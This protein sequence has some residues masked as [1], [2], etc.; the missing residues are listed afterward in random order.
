MADRIDV[1]PQARDRRA[2]SLA[3]AGVT[4]LLLGACQLQSAPAVSGRVVERATG[5]PIVGAHVVAAW[6]IR[7][8]MSYGDVVAYGNVLETTTGV[9]GLYRFAAWGPRPVFSLGRADAE[10]TLM[11]FKRGYRYA[12]GFAGALGQPD[13]RD[14]IVLERFE[15]DGRPYRLAFTQAHID[16][17]TLKRRDE[18]TRI[19]AFLCALAGEDRAMAGRGMPDAL[20]SERQLREWGIECAR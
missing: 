18:A 15:P 4:T 19:P 9:D 2:A 20:Y 8:G 3:L 13:A 14:A 11:V 1:R 12:S 16:V 7:G 17:D 5:T 6:K 10:P